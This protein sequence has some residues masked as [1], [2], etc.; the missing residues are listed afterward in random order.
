MEASYWLSA[1]RSGEGEQS[2]NRTTGV[3]TEE[4]GFVICQPI[5]TRIIFILCQCDQSVL[6]NN[7]SYRQAGGHIDSILQ[8]ERKCDTLQT[9]NM[10]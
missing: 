3:T 4:T 1:L 10:T 6:N 5:E 9:P 8:S 7:L 2:E